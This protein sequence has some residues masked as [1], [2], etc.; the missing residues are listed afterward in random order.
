METGT[1]ERALLLGVNLH[2]GEDFERSMEEL[3]HLA[4]ACNMV[5]VGQVVQNLPK[6]HQALYMGKGK[7]LEVKEYLETEEMDVLIFDRSLTPT[8]LRNLQDLLDCPILDRTT[9][10]LEIFAVRAKT[11]EAKLQVEY[12]RLQYVLPRLTGMH[13]ALSRQGGGSGLANKGAGEKKLELDRRRI[14]KRMSELRKALE[15]IAEERKT[16]R[17]RRQG[18]R[19]PRVALVGY[20]NAGKS[21]LMNRMLDQYTRDASKKVLEKDMLFATLDTTVRRICTGNN[22][23]F[24]LSDTV[25]FIHKLPHGLVKAFRSTLEEVENA[26]LLLHI[27]DYSDPHFREQMDTTKQLLAELE[28]GNIPMITVFNKADKCGEEYPKKAGG[29]RVFI[30]AK[31]QESVRFLAGLILESIYKDYMESEFLIP[32]ERGDVV[33]YFM[34]HSHMISSEF[35]EQGT[36]IQVR[37]HPADRDKYAAYSC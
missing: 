35:E 31:D 37:C 1:G 24:L 8:Q 26:D 4:E 7:L 29:Q 32:Y 27:V 12:A 6:L 28:T 14:E 36:R 33:S 21:T 23:D 25:G 9:L 18:S 30:S 13:K 11:R 17:K 2:D 22:R 3:F 5:P 34:E 15:R 10:I 16:Q 19:V 20:T